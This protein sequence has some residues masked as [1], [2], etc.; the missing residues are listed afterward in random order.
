MRKLYLSAIAVLACLSSFAATITATATGGSWNNNNSWTTSAPVSG[1]IVIIPAGSTISVGNNVNISNVTIRVY[2]TLSVSNRLNLSGTWDIAV[3]TGGTIS[4]NGQIANSG[5]NFYTNSGPIAGPQVASSASPTFVVNTTLPVK[6]TGFSV[7]RQNNDVL[8]QW[9]TAEEVNALSYEVERST[10]GNSWNR[11]ATVG[12]KGNSSSLTNYSYTDK[13]ASAAVAYYR[14]KQ[15]D[16]DSKFIYTTTQAVKSAAST[17]DVKVA[18]INNR[19]VLQFSSPVKGDVEVRL[20]TLSGQ[21]ISKQ[22]LRQ[23]VGQVVLNTGS[24]KG[25][26]II[27][28]SNAQDINVAKQVVL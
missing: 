12:A 7:A 1:D 18:A 13:N 21:V 14:I 20:V 27:S 4:G 26:Y 3:Y 22:V 24:V 23:P 11:I 10:D 16:M 19:V 28:V 17:V 15:V 25:N 2:G 8:V 6:F 5:T 9:S